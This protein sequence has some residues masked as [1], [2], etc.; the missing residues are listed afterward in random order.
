MPKN[1]SDVFKSAAEYYA[2]YR[3]KFPPE[4]F[5][6]LIAK[7]NL[8][9]QGRL[10]DLGCG[11]GNLTI[12]LAKYFEEVV[13]LDPEQ[14][15]LDQAKIEADSKGVDNIQWLKMMAEDID[16]SL[17]KFKLATMG[18]SFHW[19]DEQIVLDKLYSLIEEGGGLAIASGTTA[20]WKNIDEEEWKAVCRQAI[21]RYL[22]ADRRAGRGTFIKPEKSF[23]DFLKESIFKNVERYEYKYER[24]RSLD[25]IVG[26][27]F[28]T[29]YATPALLG[30]KKEMF[31]AE[32]RG[33]L[34]KLIPEGIYKDRVTLEVYTAYK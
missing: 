5:K 28:S 33:E 20:L 11:T 13:G 9:G 4:L 19:M 15:M 31:E 25:E 10:L 6:Y 21:Q 16:Q 18:L 3:P 24:S 27:L 8:N 30:D 2:K 29:S 22:G 17:G 26:H 1:Y 7:F 14:E 34:L 12:P 32:I 23:E